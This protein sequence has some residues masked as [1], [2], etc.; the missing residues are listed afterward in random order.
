MIQKVTIKSV[1]IDKVP[2]QYGSFKTNFKCKEYGDRWISGFARG[3]NWK[4]GDI[5][6][7]DI[8]TSDKKDKE[9]KPYLNWKFVNKEKTMELEITQIKFA[10]S[11][12]DHYLKEVAGVLKLIFPSGTTSAGTKV[13]D[14]VPNTPEQAK[15]FGEKMESYES[16]TVDDLNGE[17]NLIAEEDFNNA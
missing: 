16:K 11:K 10:L 1:W 4:D 9:N 5:V 2:T 3:C 6:E 7:L 15:E 14:F 12:H 13:P 17:L 8:I